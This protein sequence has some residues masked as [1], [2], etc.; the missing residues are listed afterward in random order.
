MFT[1]EQKA[2]IIAMFDNQTKYKTKKEFLEAVR[3]HLLKTTQ[4]NTYNPSKGNSI[5]R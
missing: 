2:K 5:K 1:D 3:E 4:I